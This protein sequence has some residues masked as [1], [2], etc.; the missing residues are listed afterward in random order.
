MMG[1]AREMDMDESIMNRVIVR[2]FF[3]GIP[4]GVVWFYY[5]GFTGVEQ[6]LKF[7]EDSK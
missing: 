1:A 6:V 7:Y 2:H 5:N 4:R 3:M